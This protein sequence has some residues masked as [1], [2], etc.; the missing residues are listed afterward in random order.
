MTTFTTA[1]QKKQNATVGSTKVK[2]YSKS[3]E[4]AVVKLA[5]HQ[6]RGIRRGTKM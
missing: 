2:V 6:L 1:A 4:C 5:E 3:S